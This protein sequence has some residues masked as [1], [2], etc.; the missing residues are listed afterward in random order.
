MTEIVDMI[1]KRVLMD[2]MDIMRQ[3]GV[4]G[5]GISKIMTIEISQQESIKNTIKGQITGIITY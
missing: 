4:I 2:L 5:T 1:D 3:D